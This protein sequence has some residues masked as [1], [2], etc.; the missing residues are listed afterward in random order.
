MRTTL[1]VNGTRHE[2]DPPPGAPLADV[3]RAGC[4]VASVQVSCSDGSCGGCTVLVGGEAVRAC[5]MFAVQGDGAEIRTV[6]GLDVADPLRAAPAHCCGAGLVM[7][8]AGALKQDPGLAGDPERLAGLLAAN[9][10]PCA[11]H[12]DIKRG[13][14][15]AVTR[16]A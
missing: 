8:A 12:E 15:D 2:V 11:G 3:L 9:A 4:G 13:V 6:E 16:A 5:L 1:I 14:L 10:C 7:L